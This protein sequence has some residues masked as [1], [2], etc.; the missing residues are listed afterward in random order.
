MLLIESTRIFRE[1]SDLLALDYNSEI[2]PREVTKINRHA[3]MSTSEIQSIALTPILILTN[4][5]VR[6]T[7]EKLCVKTTCRT[8][9][10]CIT[11][12]ALLS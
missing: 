2:F 3:I 6:Q 4:G 12:S 7:S 1:T 10:I 11:S 5:I 8:C 9:V